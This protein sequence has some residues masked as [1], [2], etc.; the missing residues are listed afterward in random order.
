MIYQPLTASLHLV[1]E[2]WIKSAHSTQPIHPKLI[3]FF[4]LSVTHTSSC[5]GV[6]VGW[7]AACDCV[8]LCCKKTASESPEIY[9]TAIDQH[10]SPPRSKGQK[11]GLNK[12]VMA[13]G[14]G[15]RVNVRFSE[16]NIFDVS[17]QTR[18]LA[19]TCILCISSSGKRDDWLWE[20][21]HDCTWVTTAVWCCFF[22]LICWYGKLGSRHTSLDSSCLL[23]I[24]SLNKETKWQ[25]A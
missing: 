4:Q 19:I 2:W 8:C 12:V 9:S 16:F 6:E 3:S 1:S 21:M 22:C 11:S 13:A 20:D 5:W 10:V 18:N 15:L 24:M 17:I 25:K 23:N 14:M 7:S